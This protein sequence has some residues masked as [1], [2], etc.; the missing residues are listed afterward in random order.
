MPII[1]DIVIP[2]LEYFLGWKTAADWIFEP[3]FDLLPS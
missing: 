3:Q 1:N 2:D